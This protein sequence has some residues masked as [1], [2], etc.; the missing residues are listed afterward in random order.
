MPP[1]QLVLRDRGDG[2]E[3]LDAVENPLAKGPDELES[4]DASLH[5]PRLGT[6]AFVRL[7][8]ALSDRGF[9]V[10]RFEFRDR[11]MHPVEGEEADEVSAKLRELISDGDVSGALRY[12]NREAEDIYI[13]AITV[14]E[15]SRRRFRL[16]RFG[17]ITGN[18][19]SPDELIS[20]LRV[21]WSKVRLG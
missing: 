20:A 2:S 9:R 5:V 18:N 13:V 17:S 19:S 11:R 1:V 15:P 7:V 21:A 3:Q 8:A 12:L 14:S 10:E 6:D 16:G 4:D